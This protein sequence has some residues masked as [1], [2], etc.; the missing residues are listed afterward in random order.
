MILLQRVAIWWCIKLCAIFFLDH[1]VYFLPTDGQPVS[2]WKTRGQQY[3]QC[4]HCSFI[5]SNGPLISTS[6]YSVLIHWRTN[7]N[8]YYCTHFY[9]VI[10]SVVTSKTVTARRIIS[11]LPV[12]MSWVNKVSFRP[13]FE[14][15]QWR[16]YTYCS[17]KGMP[18][19]RYNHCMSGYHSLAGCCT[20]RLNQGVIVLCSS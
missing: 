8:D 9:P 14:N 20:R 11:L 10:V 16:A 4:I 18:Q 7:N 5:H 19:S 1:S 2:S 6:Q 13:G 3:Q 15:S 12:I 17:W